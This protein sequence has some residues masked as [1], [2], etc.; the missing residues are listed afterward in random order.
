[1]STDTLQTVLGV[2]KGVVVAV[3]DYAIH[4]TAVPDFS[5][6]APSFLLG[7]VF[8]VIEAVKGYYAG[9]VK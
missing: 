6:T 9:G 4:A 8:A 5:V 2:A 3:A 7:I 1:M